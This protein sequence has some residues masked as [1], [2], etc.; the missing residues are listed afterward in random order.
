MRHLPVAA[1]LTAQ[2]LFATGMR[3]VAKKLLEGCEPKGGWKSWLE[4]ET[5]TI[6]KDHQDSI[7]NWCEAMKKS[8]RE[9][10]LEEWNTI[11]VLWASDNTEYE[12]G[13]ETYAQ[14]CLQTQDCINL[15]WSGL[16]S[17]CPEMSSV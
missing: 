12:C 17:Y 7:E 13:E 15:L 3:P 14:Q 16:R 9:E 2:I 11:T 8:L 5:V 1:F 10:T 6:H 4:G